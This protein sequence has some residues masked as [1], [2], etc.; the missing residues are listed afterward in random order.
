M[1]RIYQVTN[2]RDLRKFVR[3]PWKVYKDDPN[4]VP[5]LLSDQLATL[6]PSKGSFY[7]HGEVALFGA[8]RGGELAGTIAAF[9]DHRFVQHSG[10]KVG[11]FGFFEVLEDYQVAERLLES[12]CEW[13]RKRELDTVSGPNNFSDL[14]RPGV[15]IEGDE[16][17]PV[18]LQ[19]HTPPYYKDFLER[20]GF[21]KDHDLYAWRAHRSQIGEGWKNVPPQLLRVAQVAK[22]QANVSIR[23][24]RMEKW[25]EEIHAAYQ[26]FV[27]T[28]DYLPE[29]MPITED[30]FH[31]F[32]DPLKAF[33]D[34]DLALMAEVN[35][36]AIGFIVAL[37][38]INQVLIHLNGR[39]FPFGWLKVKPLVR[40][41]NVATFKLMGLLEEYR[42]RGID[43]ILYMEAVKAIYE[44][45]YEWI[46]GSVTSENNPIV[47]LIA[48]RL[49]AEQY[50]HYRVYKMNLEICG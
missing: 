38:D 9:V 2:R 25:D 13:L 8:Q 49:G 37:P 4:W 47:N 46:D 45:G 41:I 26:L 50:K 30:E 22:D 10:Q 43:A 15:L 48:R 42:N 35:G 33:L 24:V 27:G 34:P 44:K 29:H 28:L 20:Y 23:K 32:A 31:G 1:V 17:P 18:M 7:S 6:D 11:G 14:E 19:A 5:L 36:K 40:K 39:L 3:F 16:C 12:A 21:Q